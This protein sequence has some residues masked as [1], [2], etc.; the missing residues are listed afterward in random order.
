MVQWFNL[1]VIR[2]NKNLFKYTYKI[3]IIKIKSRAF[4]KND[5]QI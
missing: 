5:C 1:I 4:D 3:R 2:F